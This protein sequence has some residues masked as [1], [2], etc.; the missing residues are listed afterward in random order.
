MLRGILWGEASG[1]DLRQIQDG[2]QG[3]R[4]HLATSEVLF[5]GH[6]RDVFR[7]AAAQLEHALGDLR[8]AHDRALTRQVVRAKLGT[9]GQQVND[10]ARKVGREGQATH[11][12]GHDRGGRALI[13]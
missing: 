10:A 8:P 5:R 6:G 13:R 1:L 9:G 11:L 4:C 12:I 3:A 2:G 7:I